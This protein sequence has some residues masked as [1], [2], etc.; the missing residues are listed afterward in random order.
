MFKKK[1]NSKLPN[2]LPSGEDQEAYSYCVR[3][4]IRISP[5]GIQNE[6]GKWKIGINVGPYIKGEKTNIAPHLYD[7]DT[8]WP[9]YY[10]MCRYYYNK[11]NNEK[12]I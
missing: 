5:L 8:I 11:R 1:K 2:Y 3:N 10:E 12:Q 7:V 4:N 6:S 9:S